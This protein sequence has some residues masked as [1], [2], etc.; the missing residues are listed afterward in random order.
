MKN[1]EKKMAELAAEIVKHDTG[2][3]NLERI[4]CDANNMTCTECPIKKECDGAQAG[5]KGIDALNEW[6]RQ[7]VEDEG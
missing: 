3:T 6:L 4:I 1:F 5:K 7:E 2:E